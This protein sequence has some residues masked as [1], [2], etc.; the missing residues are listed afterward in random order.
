M[1]GTGSPADQQGQA[2]INANADTPAGV[3]AAANVEAPASGDANLSPDASSAPVTEGA[4]KD[5]TKP[6]LTDV[7]RAAAQVDD[8]GKSP[9]PAESGKDKSVVADA[10]APKADAHDPA[11]DAKLPFHNHPRWKEVTGQNKALSEK[12]ATL[13]PDAEQ[14]GK[15]QSFMD[16]HHLSH[17]EV[18]ELFIVGA[19]AK[20]GDVRVLQK[21]DEYRDKL[22]TALGE[23]LPADIQDQVDSGA[24]TEAAGKEMS[25][26]RAKNTKTEADVS[27]NREQS[28]RQRQETDATNH[29]NACR[30]KQKHER[31][32]RI[33]RRKR[34][35][36][37]VTRAPSFKSAAFLRPRLMLSKSL[38]TP[39]PRS[40]RICPP[41]CQ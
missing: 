8:Q 29:A 15:I 25:V 31:P 7:L 1:S 26:L 36:S 14:Y 23:K 21:I 12:V 4:K 40:T 33:L 38:R 10:N 18:G 17:D 3:N 11:D 30:G 39:M 41:L 32:I 24:I 37:H 19:M 28:E 35:Q 6:T 5:V 22:A 9:D 2:D 27:R 34:M 16:E 20:A 13:T